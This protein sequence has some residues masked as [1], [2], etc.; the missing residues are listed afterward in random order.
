MGGGQR[1][2]KPEATAMQPTLLVLAAGIGSRYGGLKQVEPV[3]PNG[4]IILEYSVFDALRAGFGRVVFVIRKSI[5]NDFKQQIASRLEGKIEIGYAYQ[6]LD[7]LP[8][9][10]SPPQG[11]TKPWGTGHAILVAK[12]EVTT[13]FAAIN[14]DDFYGPNAFRMIA[15]ELQSAQPDRYSMV[16]FVLRN[17][18][19][20]HGY[21]S[22]GVCSCRQ[23]LLESVVEHPK[24]FREGEA[25]R[26]EGDETVHLSGDETV[27]MNLWGFHPG[28]FAHLDRQFQEFL[29]A[30]G[31]EEK[32]EFY[33]PSV[34]DRLIGEKQASVHVRTSPDRW[35]GVTYP[36]DKPVV[37]AGISNLVNDGVYPQCLWN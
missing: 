30:R 11:R 22:R 27:S 24:I 4:E 26:S 21:V 6:E 15:E 29:A 2:A 19:S 36:E 18:L 32:S 33:I 16:G 8:S 14:A 12:D 28:L 3:G 5:E 20:E 13:P 9:P 31:Q 23:D 35:F 10:F 7:A 25:A 17:T 37:A 34:V 1:A